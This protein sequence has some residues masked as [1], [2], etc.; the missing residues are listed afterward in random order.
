MATTKIIDV[1]EHQGKIDWAAVKMAG[2]TG[3][4]VRAGWTWY[5]GG[6]DIDDRFCANVR[7]AQD[8]G[9]AVGVYVYSYDL[10]AAAAKAGAQRLMEVIKPYKLTLPVAF[11]MEYEAFNVGTGSGKVNTDI[12]VAFLDVLEAAGYYSMLYCSADF[13]TRHLDATRLTKY[14][15]WIAQYAPNCTYKGSYGMWQYGVLGTTGVKGRDYTITGTVPGIATNCDVNYS[16]KDYPVIIKGAGLNGWG[17]APAP[18][19]A[20]PCVHCATLRATLETA[21]DSLKWMTVDRDSRKIKLH[22]IAQL[23][24]EE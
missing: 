15:K 7:G 12:C 20:V 21:E 10:S 4:M 9:L 23:A 22:K 6:M 17:K 19:E 18:P 11:D 3:A 13:I 8:A 1:S 14:D 24:A 16:Y 5:N 2:Y